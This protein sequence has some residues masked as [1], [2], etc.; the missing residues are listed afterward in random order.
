ME[1]HQQTGSFVRA[2][3]SLDNSISTPLIAE[4][5]ETNVQLRILEE[6]DCIEIQNFLFAQPIDIKRIN[7]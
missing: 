7:R 4:S 5:I 2:I 6:K 3:I 1:T